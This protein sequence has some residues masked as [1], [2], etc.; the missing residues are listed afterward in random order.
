NTGATGLTTG[1]QEKEYTLLFAK[2]LKH[3]LERKGAQVL[4]T[5]EADISIETSD[6]M[7]M[8]NKENPDILISLHLNSSSNTNV[9]GVSTYY[10]HIG[11]RPLSQKILSRML[12]L[13]LHEFGNVGSFNF[14]LNGPT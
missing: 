10:R 3:V 12:D 4:M 14:T 5:R 9:Q 13:N 6:R 8:L 7:I 1:I 2:E 11:F